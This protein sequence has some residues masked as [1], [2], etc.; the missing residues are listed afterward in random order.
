MFPH[1][2]SM[3]D[4]G[5]ARGGAAPLLRR[6]HARQASGSSCPTRCTA[7]SRATGWASRRASCSRSR[8]TELTCSTRA[9]PSRAAAP[10]GRRSE[11]DAGRGL[12]VPPRRQAAP[13]PL[14]RGAA[15]GHPARG[16]R[17]DRH[18][19][20]SPASAASACRCSTRTSRRSSD[21]GPGRRS[22]PEDVEHVARLA[23]LELSR[24]RE[25]ADAPA[26]STASSRTSTSSARSTP[27]G[28]EPTSHAV[29]LTN[30]MRDDEP[31]PS[32]PRDEMLANAPD[33]QRRLLPRAEDHRGVA[34]ACWRR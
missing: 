31:R 17:R 32:L 4:A 7:A 18:R 34:A 19:A 25:G 26:S 5:R 24:G 10:R 27:T 33:R 6:H 2:R 11:P 29:P 22:S 28:V 16:R 13:R 14:G 30:V 1:S 15:R 23:R 21:G 20:T 3:N 9:G 12:P 8:R